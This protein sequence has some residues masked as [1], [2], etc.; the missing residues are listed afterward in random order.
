MLQEANKFVRVRILP[1][2]SVHQSR[3]IPIPLFARGPP[4]DTSGAAT[5]MG[6]LVDA[7]VTLSDP[8]RLGRRG[9]AC[10]RLKCR[11]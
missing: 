7:F 5:F 3:A 2:A 1:D 6:R 8:V 4:G 10:G 11:H 9:T